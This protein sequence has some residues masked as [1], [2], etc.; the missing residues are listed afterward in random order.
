MSPRGFV[1]SSGFAFAFAAGWPAGSRSVGRLA[2]RGGITWESVGASVG[3]N[4]AAGDGV[5]SAFRGVG[6][7]VGSPGSDRVVEG[8]AGFV[9]ANGV[10]VGVGEV[11]SHASSDAKVGSGSRVLTAAWSSGVGVEDVNCSSSGGVVSIGLG[12][13]SSQSAGS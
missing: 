4:G 10:G 1:R 6:K 9:S 5:G 2:G 3:G 12:F 7:S 13:A 8:P 11:E